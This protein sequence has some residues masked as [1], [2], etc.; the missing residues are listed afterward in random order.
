MISDEN[1]GGA[2]VR[3]TFT[4]GGEHLKP[5]TTLS[6]EEL[7]AFSLP[8]RRALIDAGY[9]EPWVTPA[10]ANTGKRVIVHRGGGAYDV[11]VGRL[12]KEPLTK[13]EAEKL[14][15]RPQ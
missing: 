14:A 6:R 9:I 11:Y 8:N 2:F 10:G 3:R 12:N 13:D 5:G 7:L 1:L 4:R 15:G